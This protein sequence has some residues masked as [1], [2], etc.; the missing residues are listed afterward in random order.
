MWCSGKLKQDNL[1]EI[2]ILENRILKAEHENK[3]DII[4]DSK[5][6]LKELQQL[7]SE[8][9]RIR[10]RVQWFEEGEKPTRYFHN[11]EK[12]NAKG[13]AWDKILNEKGEMV[14]GTEKIMDVQCEFYQ[15]LYTTEGVDEDTGKEFGGSI[16]K[17]VPEHRRIDLNRDISLAE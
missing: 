12:R 13:K 1:E 17:K 7:K 3:Y 16:I 9:A 4:A 14:Y 5:M 6:R 8:G 10:S 15:K 2:N 11:L